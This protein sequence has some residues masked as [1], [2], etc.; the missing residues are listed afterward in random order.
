M[1]FA[2]RKERVS[3][4]SNKGQQGEGESSQVRTFA[5]KKISTT[6]AAIT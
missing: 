5:F 2:L 1:T 4:K 3:E 6:I